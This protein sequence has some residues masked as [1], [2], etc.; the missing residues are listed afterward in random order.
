MD[1]VITVLVHMNIVT[2][3][4]IFLVNKQLFGQYHTAIGLSVPDGKLVCS[5]AC[6]QLLLAVVTILIMMLI[7]QKD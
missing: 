6:I 4:K 1:S 2:V 3:F 7:S 5:R